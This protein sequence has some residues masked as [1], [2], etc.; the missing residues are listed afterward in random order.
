MDSKPSAADV[1]AQRHVTLLEQ[2]KDKLTKKAGRGVLDV[3]VAFIHSP[4]HLLSRLHSVCFE[5][6]AIA[7][8]V[9]VQTISRLTPRHQSF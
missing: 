3:D 7:T 8:A 5:P 2:N 1:R 6:L 9:C 4:A